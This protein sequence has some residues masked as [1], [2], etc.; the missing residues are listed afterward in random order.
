MRS[1]TSCKLEALTSVPSGHHWKYFHQKGSHASFC[2]LFCLRLA[3]GKPS[4]H[5]QYF[6]NNSGNLRMPWIT[7]V[8]IKARAGRRPS[9]ANCSHP[10]PLQL[11]FFFF[12]LS[13]RWSYFLPGP[14]MDVA[15]A[16]K[17]GKK[18]TSQ[19]LEDQKKV[20]LIFF[21]YSLNTGL[22]SCL[23]WIRVL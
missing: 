10:D 12:P 16:S 22:I 5:H 8:R 19:K 3:P 9:S 20:G 21:G 17:H 14:G 18:S 23:V 13:F 4:K 15:E 11:F 7:C 6:K 2:R 1:S